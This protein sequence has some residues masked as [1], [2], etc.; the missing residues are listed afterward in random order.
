MALSKEERAKM[1]AIVNGA[2]QRRSQAQTQP[3][4]Q[5]QPQAQ[6][7]LQK[8]GQVG[9]GVSN[10]LMPETTKR[11]GEIVQNPKELTSFLP[12]SLRTGKFNLVDMPD[13]ESMKNVPALKEIEQN[14]FLEKLL[15]PIAGKLINKTVGK[16]KNLLSLTGNII[17]HPTK[18]SVAKATEATVKKASNE[19]RATL[20]REFD[21]VPGLFDEITKAVTDKYGKGKDVLAKLDTLLK[22]K[23]P[24]DMNIASAMNPTE[25]YEW[26]K[27]LLA[28]HGKSII[29]KLF[30]GTSLDDK[31]AGTA[32]GTISQSLHQV[33]PDTLPL[34]KLYTF[35]ANKKLGI[36]FTEGDVPTLA[37]KA[38]IAYLLKN[39]L[40]GIVNEVKGSSTGY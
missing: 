30:Q 6:N 22:E 33:A 7:L 2:K 37:G 1:N 5:Q 10:F 11:A 20:L 18:G 8:A 9:Y 19:G 3:Q 4:A 14:I 27:Q 34:D 13:Q 24:S 32:R 17:K 35:Y 26:R 12:N 23:L 39:L 40:P 29:E 16:T 38:A 36:P 31:I 21:N 15:A 28:K 25:Q